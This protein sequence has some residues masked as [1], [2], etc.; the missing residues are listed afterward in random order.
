MPALPPVGH[1]GL[2]A[3]DENGDVDESFRAL[4]EGLRTTLPGVQ[5]LFAFLLILPLQSRFVEIGDPVRITYFAAL[6]SAAISSV[7]LIAPSVHQRVRAPVTGVARR[8][9]A[10]LR[11]SAVVTIV[12]TVFFL[13]ALGSSVYVVSAIVFATAT[14]AAIPTA[15]VVALAGWAWFYVPVVRWRRDGRRASGG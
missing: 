8:H 3:P 1:P 5:V 6:L 13:V 12:G 15:V 4:L 2:S 14:W 10:H 11:F 7:L 9:R